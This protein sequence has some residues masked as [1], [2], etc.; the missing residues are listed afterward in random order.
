MSTP[1][2]VPSRAFADRRYLRCPLAEPVRVTVLRPGGACSATG[3]GLNLGEGGIAISWAGEVCVADSVAVT[4]PLADL[5]LGLEARAVVR[6]CVASHSGLEF[7]GL[8]RY[9]HAAIREWIRQQQ[10]KPNLERRSRP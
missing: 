4:F 3:H 6:Y 7:E 1:G 8:T 10:S 9:Q 5:G 2:Q